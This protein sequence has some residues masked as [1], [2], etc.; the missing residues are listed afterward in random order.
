MTHVI[1]RVLDPQAEGKLGRRSNPQPSLAAKQSCATTWGIQTRSW[2]DCDSAFCQITS[3]FL[4][5]VTAQCMRERARSPVAYAGGVSRFIA[6]CVRSAAVAIIHHAPARTS[7]GKQPSTEAPRG[8]RGRRVDYVVVKSIPHCRQTHGH[9]LA[10][11]SLKM[12]ADR[13]R[14]LQPPLHPRTVLS[15]MTCAPVSPVASSLCFHR[16]KPATLRATA[17]PR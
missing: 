2:V 16:V 8:G 3:V 1:R 10:S 4:V 11:S 5:I 14:S 13:P 6:C 9:A 7:V 15:L 12:P 17:R